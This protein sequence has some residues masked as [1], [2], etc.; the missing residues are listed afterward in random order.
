MP[1]FKKIGMHKI[2]TPEGD[3]VLRR[4][5]F[6]ERERNA[7]PV[8]QLPGLSATPGVQTCSVA[9]DDTLRRAV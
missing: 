2:G 5:T 8:L 9:S 4:L 6:S 3:E 1:E 7:D